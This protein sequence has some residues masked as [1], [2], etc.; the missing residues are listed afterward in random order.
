[1]DSPQSFGQWLRNRRRGFDLTQAEL[2]RCVGCA[3][4]TIKKL[5][6]DELRPSR[7][8]AEVV[9][10]K[11]GVEPQE[12]DALVRFARGGLE[13]DPLYLKHHKNNLPA[14]LTSFIGREKEIAQIKQAICEHRLV[15]LTGSG[16]TGKTRL[17]LK[18]AADLLDEFPNGAWFIEL[19]PLT[20]GNLISQT[21]ISVLNLHADNGRTAL[22]FLCDYLG[23]KK[24][25]LILDNCEHLIEAC[26]K[27]AEVLLNAA[28]GLK[29]LAS[30]REA[31][32]VRGE[33]AWIVP[34]LSLP[35]IKNL[36]KIEQLSQY[37]AMQ[38]F[39]E[40][41]R[42]V[43]PHFNVTNSNAPAVAQICYHLD[44]IPL[45]IELAAA[46]IKMMTAEQ[47]NAHLDDRFHLLTSGS[48]T[49]LPRQQTLR[50]AIDWSY[51]LLTEQERLIMQR[52]TV[53][54]GGWTLDAAEQIC[55]D[56]KIGE[57]EILELL[58][59]LVDKSMVIADE[60]FDSVRYRILETVRQYAYEKLLEN[61]GEEAAHDR[62]LD[63][64]LKLGEEARPKLC[65]AEW[66]L[67][68]QRL[69]G[70]WDN[71][72]AALEW[73]LG[74]GA[75]HEAERGLQLANIYS[76]I[77]PENTHSGAE[78]LAWIQKGLSFLRGESAEANLLRAESLAC[79]GYW[80]SYVLGNVDLGSTLLEEGVALYRANPLTTLLD[81][82]WALC[83]LGKSYW[84]RY[85]EKTQALAAESVALCRKVGPAAQWQL[86][87]AL[88]TEGDAAYGNNDY[89][90]ARMRVQESKV[91]FEQMGDLINEAW[92]LDHLGYVVEVQEDYARARPYF[93]EALCLCQQAEQS[94]P[95]GVQNN[96]IWFRR[97]LARLDRLMG[98]YET[99][100]VC[101][102][103]SLLYCQETGDKLS[104]G[105]TLLELGRTALGQGNYKRAAETLRESLLQTREI[106]NE[107][108]MGICMTALAE[109]FWGLGQFIKSARLL[110]ALESDSKIGWAASARAAYNKSVE[111]VKVVLGEEAFVIARTEGKAMTLDQAVEYA[112]KVE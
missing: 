105:A 88:Y 73:S 45:A 109:A 33:T 1:M 77:L 71:F 84:D 83:E 27:L 50:A 25:L 78:V 46:R 5:E 91:L 66:L 34:S 64:Y 52:L 22:Q 42:L 8:L 96:A 3:R 65:S 36:P 67:W 68:Q 106:R 16:G 47:I 44:G 20:D 79:S 111:A 38:L 58:T 110:G 80:N 61:G 100:R 26:G 81:L 7:Q 59:H 37:E 29:I 55:R 15:T 19:A 95:E 21:I 60:Q 49:A 53:F 14:E 62:H 82:A 87:K 72:R 57:R 85:P 56:D 18:V 99:A 76:R 63:Y 32:G 107:R 104:I 10:R 43:Q 9:I 12:I 41:A 30:S 89:E 101:L 39:I 28:P 98:N 6:A 94:F 74:K 23:E 97:D 69:K 75:T 48:R 92:S 2:A 4:V 35:D 24:T 103:E 40:R 31:L 13:P 54:A 51:N 102:E 17:S 112:L 11:L 90:A 93:K 86:A 70:E 108:F